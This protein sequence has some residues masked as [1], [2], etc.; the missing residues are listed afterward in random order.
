MWN[1][2]FKHWII[3]PAREQDNPAPE[4]ILII[5]YAHTTS[6]ISHNSISYLRKSW[7]SSTKEPYSKDEMKN[8]WVTCKEAKEINGT[9][10]SSSMAEMRSD[11]RSKQRSGSGG[12]WAAETTMDSSCA[13]KTPKRERGTFSLTY[14]FTIVEVWAENQEEVSSSS[15]A[16]AFLLRLQRV[17]RIPG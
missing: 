2:L 16:G 6:I 1:V 10:G 3:T 13:T 8:Y 4:I 17:N 12:C 14:V 5:K 7:Q 9:L 11:R 15:D